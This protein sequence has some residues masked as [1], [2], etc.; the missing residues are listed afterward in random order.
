MDI[1][2]DAPPR[3]HWYLAGVWPLVF[4]I[5]LATVVA[6]LS[7]VWIA[8]YRPDPLVDGG[9]RPD[10]AAAHAA[11]A[12]DEAA[13]RLAV[14]GDLSVRDRSLTMT[15]SA[16]GTLPR[17]LRVV[18]A[19]PQ[20]ETHDQVVIAERAPDGSY[21]ASLDTLDTAAWYVAVTPTDGRWRVVGQVGGRQPHTTLAP[22][23]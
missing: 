10:I 22:R 19:H 12:A 9:D 17:Q 11:P 2:V 3:D 16:T 20:R 18:L 1:A 13:R 7:T 6:G 14:H 23:R 15:L 21:Q 5:P 4:F 8:N